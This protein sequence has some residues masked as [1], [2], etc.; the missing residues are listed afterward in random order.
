MN[1]VLG[2]EGSSH[3]GGSWQHG[4]TLL[5]L[6]VGVSLWRRSSGMKPERW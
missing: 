4:V 1:R 3:P 5:E 6:S 2:G